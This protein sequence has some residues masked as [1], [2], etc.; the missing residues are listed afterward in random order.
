M[1]TLGSAASLDA[2]DFFEQSAAAA[3]KLGRRAVLIYGRDCERPNVGDQD[4]ACWDFAPY[5][6]VFSRAA[7]IVHQGGVGTTGQ[8]LRSGRPQIIVP[9]SHDQPDNAA[10]CR[11]SGLAETIARDSYRADTAAAALQKVLSNTSY[12]QS[13]FAASQ[14]VRSEHGTQMACDAIEDILRK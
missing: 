1:F 3:R 10:R 4:M 12:E 9:F 6:L 7:C 13:A 11:R 5:S 2:G 14:I 8:A